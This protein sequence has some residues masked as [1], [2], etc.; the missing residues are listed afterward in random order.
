[1]KRTLSMVLVLLLVAMS[2]FAAGQGEAAAKSKD[3]TVVF[4]PKLSGNAFF[5]AANEGA[6]AYAAKQGFT[7]KYDGNPEASVANQVT[8][9]DNAINSGADAVCVSSVD[10]TGLDDIMKEAMKAG[11]AVVTWDSDV[12]GDART[13]MV[14]QGTPD[15]LG[16]MLV[17]MLADSLK[18]RGKD[19]AKDA[20]KYAWH[21]S[22][23]TVADQNSWRVAGEEYIRKAYP[24]WVNVNPS[25]FYSEQDAEKAITIGEAI[26]MAH[27]DIDGIICNDSTALPGQAQ[28]AQN[29]GKD[30]NDVSITGFAPP[31]SMKQYANAGVLARWGL[32]DCQIQGALG[33]YLAYYLA[34]GNEIKVGDKIAV[35]EIGTVEVLPNTV[36]DASAYTAEDSGVVL[37]PERAV[38]TVENMN[39]YNF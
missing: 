11:L 18:E 7:V 29:L 10:A 35:P 34:S 17:D 13:V 14:S 22:Q 38:F 5:E 16:K 1:M 2:V 28:A 24:N 19:P 6:Q 37:L 9:I 27:P 3:V 23:A 21:Y 30:K 8:I 20:I 25:N 31:N 12:S 33:C 15:I 39:N 4:V 36:L 32:W 26:L